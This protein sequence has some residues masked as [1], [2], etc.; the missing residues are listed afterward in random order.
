MVS[1]YDTFGPITR[2]IKLIDAQR[3]ASEGAVNAIGTNAI[4]TAL[5]WL[6]KEYDIRD[7][8]HIT[9]FIR[10]YPLYSFGETI[11]KH[12]GEEAQPATPSLIHLI[13]NGKDA[14]VRI[15][16]LYLLSKVNKDV[17]VIVPAYIDC[18]KNDPDAK[19][20]LLALVY[21]VEDIGLDSK[22]GNALVGA[23]VHDPDE[24]V[25]DYANSYMVQSDLYFGGSLGF[26]LKTS[27]T[28]SGIHK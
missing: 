18:A 13:K 8:F 11:F 9:A 15:K 24:K 14:E 28:N 21:V 20:R 19:V 27:D 3:E 16:T 2:S 6:S 7:R 10:G 26:L 23:L 17:N 12:L 1:Y 25:R 4:P 5:R 22:A